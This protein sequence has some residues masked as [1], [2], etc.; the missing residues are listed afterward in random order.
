L[1]HEERLSLLQLNKQECAHFYHAAVLG[2]RMLDRGQE[3]RFG[4]NADANWRAFSG[5]LHA[6][7]RL[8]LLLRDAATVYPAAFSPRVVF[9]LSGLAQDE[10]FGPDWPALSA[11]DAIQMLQRTVEPSMTAEQ[12]LIA[13]AALWDIKPATLPPEAL[14]AIAPATRIV[15]SGVGALLALFKRFASDKTLDFVDQIIW[16]TDLIAERHL[17]GLAAA[18][19]QNNRRPECY[20]AQ[21]ALASSKSLLGRLAVLSNDSPEALRKSLSAVVKGA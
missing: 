11:A 17:F 21:Q 6:G 16:V 12:V 1:L 18:L 5:E 10:P 19:L 3:R 13:A 20:S 7:D 15:A 2:L 4:A 8:N 9:G 14:P